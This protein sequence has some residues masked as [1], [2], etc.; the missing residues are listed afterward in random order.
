MKLRPTEGQLQLAQRLRA[1]DIVVLLGRLQQL[2]HAR[3]DRTA[4]TVLGGVILW[5]NSTS[6]LAAAADRQ[7]AG[8]RCAHCHAYVNLPGEVPDL[9]LRV[10]QVAR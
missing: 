6:A 1:D 10:R 8:R 9:I 2:A 5:M 4:V 7:L 3:E